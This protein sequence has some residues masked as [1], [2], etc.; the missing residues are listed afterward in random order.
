[1][2]KPMLITIQHFV[3]SCQR[4]VI[5][6]CNNQKHKVMAHQN[7]FVN[8]I[9]SKVFFPREYSRKESICVTERPSKFTFAVQKSLTALPVSEVL[10]YIKWMANENNLCICRVKDFNRAKFELIEAINKN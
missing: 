2:N 4:G 6:L 3:L 10:P 7:I 1:M 9:I 5:H 8:D